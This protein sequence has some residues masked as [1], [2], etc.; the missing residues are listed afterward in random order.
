MKLTDIPYFKTVI[1][2]CTVCETCGNRT[3]EVKSGSGIEDKGIRFTLKITDPSDLNRDMLKSE[4]AS[5]EIP[6][7]D[8]FVNSGTLGGKFTTLEGIIKDFREQLE[9]TSPFLAGGDSET[10]DKQSHMSKCLEQLAEIQEGKRLDVTVIVED[11]AGNSY[12]QVIFQIKKNIESIINF[13][14]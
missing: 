8:F 11:P 3:S 6:E 9:Q 5:I 4:T 12:L 1:I 14:K 10:K 2:M 7:I 13:F